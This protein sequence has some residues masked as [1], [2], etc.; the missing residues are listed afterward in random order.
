MDKNFNDIYQSLA[1]DLVNDIFYAQ[2]LSN[3]GKV[4][5]IR[6]YTEILV[7]AMLKIE[8][9]ERLTLGDKKVTRFLAE[10]RLKSS[11]HCSVVQA[12]EYIRD[13]GNS[14]TH[15]LY[16]GTISSF[17][18][19]QAIFC[20]AKIY[21][22]F[23]V[24]YFHRFKFGYNPVAMA[25][26][27]LL[28]PRF[29]LLVLITLHR[30]L[31]QD[32]AIT[33]KMIILLFKVR[34]IERMKWWVE[35]NKAKLEQISHYYDCNEADVKAIIKQDYTAYDVAI[36]K[37]NLNIH[38]TPYESFERPAERYR[39]Y[40]AEM[41]LYQVPEVVELKGIMDFVYLGLR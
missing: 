36:A 19:S 26:F 30:Q 35:R 12:V 41:S 9:S 11:Y 8:A 31:P 27:Q 3:R 24:D 22:S 23:F 38:P 34:G 33:E 25:L 2:G 40:V 17:Q 13:L 5:L 4:A 1:S 15:T 20:L 21:A 28:P 14:A 6:Q 10:Y 29:R 32:F 39:D 7:R 16:T 18:V 37:M